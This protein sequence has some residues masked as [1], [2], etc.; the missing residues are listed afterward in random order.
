MSSDGVGVVDLQTIMHENLS[1]VGHVGLRASLAYAH[2]LVAAGE[3]AGG[4][5]F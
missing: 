1:C 2:E 5:C 3:G 4:P